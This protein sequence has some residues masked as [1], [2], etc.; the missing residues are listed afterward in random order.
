MA[1]HEWRRHR[2]KVIWQLLG[3]TTVAVAFA[4][5]GLNVCA[6]F[7]NVVIFCL[8]T[9]KKIEKKNYKNKIKLL[10]VSPSTFCHT[11]LR[12]TQA[13][14]YR[15]S[16]TKINFG[17][18]I[19][20]LFFRFPFLWLFSD[21]TSFYRHLRTVWLLLFFIQINI[22]IASFNVHLE[23]YGRFYLN[24]SRI[25]IGLYS[26]IIIVFPNKK[27]FEL[28]CFRNEFLNCPIVLPWV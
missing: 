17:S 16:L 5:A 6:Q 22:W 27:S 9:Q 3:V 8:F 2:L 23:F 21:A 7:S 15:K 12:T 11:F 14:H 24:I 19:W 1:C 25:W 13:Q 28:S 26:L 10:S 20:W 4:I 18:R